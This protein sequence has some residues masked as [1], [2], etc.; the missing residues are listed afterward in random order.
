VNNQLHQLIEEHGAPL[1]V[2]DGDVIANKYNEFVDAFSVKNLEIHY[3]CKALTNLS[4]LSLMKSL[5]SK[6]DCVSVQEIQLGLKAGFSGDEIMFTPNGVG[7]KEYD[8][9]IEL[10][11]KI[12]VDNVQMLEYLGGAYPDLEICV[13][14]NPHLMG[15]GNSKISVGHIDSK[16]GISIHQMPLVHRIANK[17]G[18]KITGIHVHTGSD[19]HDGDIFIRA[20]ELIL[21]AGESF[22]DL[23]YVD[24]GSGFKVAYKPNDYSTDIKKFG[25]KFSEVFN[26]FCEKMGKDFTL[27]FEPG[28]YLVSEAGSFLT[29]VNVVKQTTACTFV[30]IDSG[31]N[32]LIRPMFYDSY[33]HIDNLSNPD[34]DEKLYNVVGYICESDTFANDRIITEVRKGDILRFRNAGAYCFSMSSNYNSRYRPPEVLLRNGEA[35]LI[36]ERETIDDLIK[37][38]KLVIMVSKLLDL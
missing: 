15:G 11:V 7:E 29:K 10:G 6:L 5:G 37:G 25:K 9:A 34:G 28:K 20:A 17:Y 19:I 12:N 16:F 36:R 30:H 1:Y 4:V 31:F 33:H 23:K 2:Y 26:A 21:T 27:K 13:R 35:H 32:H 3:A 14:I 38:Q 22:P 24:F 8:K 18:I